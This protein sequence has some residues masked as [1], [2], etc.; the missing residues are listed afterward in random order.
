MARSDERFRETFNAV[1]A[2]C[3]QMRPGELLPSELALSARFDASRTVI[4]SILERM[5]KAGLVQWNGRQKVLLRLP[6]DEDR[7][8][9][10]EHQVSPDELEQ[11]FLDWILRFDVAPGTA[12]NVAELARQFR[13][14]SY[15][16]QEFLASLSRFG[17]V[18]RRPK[19]GWELVGF[20]SDFAVELSDFRMMIEV[21]A[22][23]QLVMLPADDPIWQKLDELE[24]AHRMLAVEIDARYHDFS[25]LDE[26]FHATIGSVVTNRF[27]VEFQKIISLIFHYHYQWD[28]KDER[29]RNAAAIDEHLALIV[30]LK[31]RDERAAIEAARHHLT[32]SKQTLM[33]SLR[34][35]AP[36]GDQA[37]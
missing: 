36:G 11:E 10:S 37:S 21:N 22:V 3:A 23:S 34:I 30:A 15:G 5:D 24:D 19:N 13:V 17:L 2:E 20:T 14:T 1:L 16:L 28:K 18:R 29:E 26:R 6:Y 9:L 7:L 25:L 32:R 27:V 31:A 12:L 33:S 4:R 35:H 8:P